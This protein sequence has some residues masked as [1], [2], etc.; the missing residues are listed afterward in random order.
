MRNFISVLFVFF[1]FVLSIS[2]EA[3]GLTNLEMTLHGLGG[4]AL[5]LLGMKIYKADKNGN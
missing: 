2:M 5:V 1:G 3:P 4:M